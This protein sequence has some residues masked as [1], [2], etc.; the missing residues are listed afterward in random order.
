MTGPRNGL[1]LPRVVLVTGTDT[2]V[3]KTVATAAV[4][5]VARGRGTAV[6]VVKP[7]QT[8]LPPGVPGDAHVAGRLAGLP[9][10]HEG[11]R[12]AEPLAPETAARRA[13]AALPTVAEQA[14]AVRRLAAG[15]DLVLVEGSGGL[16]V[17][18]DLGG[19]TLADLGAALASPGGLPAAFLVVVRAGL[20]TLN[21]AELTVAALRARRLPVLGLVV[22]SW[23][24]RPG[25]AERSNLADLPRLT[26]V[27]LLGRLPA[28]AGD[29]TP[30]AFAR[31]APGWLPGLA[32]PRPTPPN[33]PL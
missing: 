22:G 1:D 8:G 31:A 7:V 17:R 19:A 14:A 15:H 18:L 21:H 12:L 3:G 2:E 28:G 10:V 23:P 11:A 25:L 33:D 27:P 9:E 26:G 29:L 24:A 20:G 4:A 32:Q 5:A 13:G 30:A 16:L 6:T